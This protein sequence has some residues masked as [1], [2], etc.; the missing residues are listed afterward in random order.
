MDK[1]KKLSSDKTKLILLI[2]IPLF[3]VLSLAFLFGK[4]QQYKQRESFVETEKE[5]E[6]EQYVAE[7]TKELN[8]LDKKEKERS[9]KAITYAPLNPTSVV[10]ICKSTKKK[11]VS[12]EP[13]SCPD[14]LFTWFGAKIREPDTKIIGYWVYFGPKNNV[15]SIYYAPHEKAKTQDKT[16]ILIPV[17]DGKF[18]ESNKFAPINLEKGKTYYLAVSAKSDSKDEFNYLP[19]GITNPDVN[20]LKAQA[21]KILFVYKY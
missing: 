19:Y 9:V 10:A 21:A 6:L 12:G 15:G 3:L 1:T 4:D 20:N 2:G 13:T 14:P 18:Q 11:I 5:T 8:P 17:L 16:K 7:P